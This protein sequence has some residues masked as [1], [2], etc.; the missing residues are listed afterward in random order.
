MWYVSL[1]GMCALCA[2]AVCVVM[3]VYWV[4]VQD[5]V[6]Q[7]KDPPGAIERHESLSL[8]TTQL[9]AALFL[10]DTLFSDVGRISALPCVRDGE[11]IES[12]VG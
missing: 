8:S 9:A 4:G 5:V 11:K 3:C 12:D 2:H 7:R 10:H 6:C 1:D